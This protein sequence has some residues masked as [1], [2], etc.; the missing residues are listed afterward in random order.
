MR[1]LNGGMSSSAIV[2]ARTNPMP[3][4]TPTSIRR[5]VASTVWLEM[6]DAPSDSLSPLDAE[7]RGNPARRA[8]ATA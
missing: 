7:S 5:A 8:L 2:L 1:M 4:L 3:R 6:C